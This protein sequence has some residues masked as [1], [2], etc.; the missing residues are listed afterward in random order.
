MASFSF[1]TLNLD[2]QINTIEAVLGLIKV[3]TSFP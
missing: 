2:R 1:K 3:S